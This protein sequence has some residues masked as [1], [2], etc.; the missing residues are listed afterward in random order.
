MGRAREFRG[1]APSKSQ[2]PL[3]AQ[4]FADYLS[5]SGENLSYGTS[6][7]V[8]RRANLER[9]GGLTARWINSEDLDLMLRLGQEPRFVL[10]RAPATYAYRKHAGSAVADRSRALAGFEHLLLREAAGLY[11]GGGARQR[12]RAEI[13]ARVLRAACL[14]CARLGEIGNAQRFYR[15]TFGWHLR[16]TRARFLLG[17]PLQ[18]LR[19]QL[20]A[21]R[22][23]AR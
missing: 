8:V 15:A 11:P 18:I 17:A 16:Q 10:V 5:A 4:C 2:A 14:H 6:G 7:L 20:R 13:L 3:R 1:A 22:H 9:V 23:T 21:L 19:A 12:E